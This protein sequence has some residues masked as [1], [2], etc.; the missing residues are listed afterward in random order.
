[1]IL[2]AGTYRFNDVLVDIP[3]LG[4]GENWFSFP[5][6]GRIVL[7]DY[8]VDS[9]FTATDI[10]FVDGK[11]V[12]LYVSDIQPNLWGYTFPT[13]KSIYGSDGF[14]D[15]GIY[16]QFLTLDVDTEVDDTFGTWYIS[17]TNYN[18]VN[19]SS[20]VTIEYNCSTIAE[21]NA[22]ETATLSCNGF[23]MA[24]DVVV[25]VGEVEAGGSGIIEVDELPEVG[26]EGAFYSVSA[27]TDVAAY[28]GGET[29]LF[30]EG[31]EAQ[32]ATFEC[33]EVATAPTAD[34]KESNMMDE[35]HLYYIKDE[36]DIFVYSDGWYPFSLLLQV[37][38]MGKIKSLSDIS[39][40]GYYAYAGGDVLYQYTNGEYIKYTPISVE[41]LAFTS[42]GDGTCYV[43]GI[44]TY[45]K[46]NLIAIPAT[47]PEG[48]TVTGI[49]EDAFENHLFS[50]VIIPD[51]VTS[52]GDS[53]FCDCRGLEEVTIPEG[54]T[55]IG[56][57]AFDRCYSLWS[58]NIPD[59]VDTIDVST[60]KEC[61]NLS[62]ISIGKDVKY[63]SEGA[64]EGCVSLT[65]ISLP[66]GVTTIGFSAFSNCKSL[67][68]IN[69]P[70]SV[71]RVET[72]A[73]SGCVSLTFNEYGN[74]C[75]LGNPNNLYVVLVKAKHTYISSVDIPS[76]TK[77][78]LGGAFEG[79]S[80]LASVSI[81]DG[82][83][84]IKMGLFEGCSSLTSVEIPD[85]VTAI[86]GY[87]FRGCTSLTSVSIPDGV[88]SI[89]AYTFKGCSSLRSVNIPSGVTSIQ[90][91]TFI[92][93]GLSS[94][95]L[96]DGIT[97]IG[98]HAFGFCT[99]LKSI[100]IPDNVKFISNGAFK[101]CRNLSS[102]T[103]GKSVTYIGSDAFRGC[104]SLSTINFTGT[105]E[106]WKA[107]SLGRDWNIDWGESPA[108]PATEVKCSDGTVTL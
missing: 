20:L 79:C 58:A 12:E 4:N 64:F 100:I 54:V 80:S 16:S 68:N 30:K 101:D 73:F 86:E 63:V 99:S 49:G 102:V 53:A 75:Y 106:Q 18:E 67:T 13:A 66:E 23:A 38:F 105:V 28:L 92:S 27:F 81:P 91:Q 36:N 44:G 26:E 51:T 43:S 96:P 10:G 34:I 87:A 77:I 21:L 94:I 1:M 29:Q 72:S 24:S 85:S 8:N 108:V 14:I 88:K 50:A 6:S 70:D 45:K 55:S 62:Q 19:K 82:I 35:W 65:D 39:E 104:G 107:I 57:W 61:V 95:S 42:N 25:K 40:N 33:Y 32:G 48:D 47:S 97:S 60:F 11:F 74:G 15:N 84:E 69:I 93:C 83:T 52:I 2:K 31:M 103:I 5:C 46:T 56:F 98:E 71:A 90:D 3:H 37:P 89:G 59:G 76:N 17:N 22:G 41:C 7:P 9:T 78:I